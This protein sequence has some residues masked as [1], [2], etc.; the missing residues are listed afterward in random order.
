MIKKID[1]LVLV[2]FLGPF[3]VSFGIALFVLIMQ[4]LWLYIDDIAGKGVN[5][6]IM[7]ELIAYLSI[8]IFPMALPVAVMLATVMVMGN[9]AERYE[10]SSMKSAGISLL[11][12][13]APLMFA[14]ALI[15]LFS[16]VC[17]DFLMPAANLKFKTRMFDIKR[18]K[19]A[20]S[21]EKGIFNEDFQ[22]FVIRVG[23]KSRDGETIRDVM[24]IDQSAGSRLKFNEILADSGQM[25][26][27]KDK[28]YFVMNLFDGVQYQEPAP[29]PSTGAQS[30]YPFVRI[31][32]E[33][34]TKV[35]DMQEF[36]LTRSDEDHFRSNRQMMSMSQL[37]HARDSMEFAMKDIRQG[38]AR[39]V[40]LSLE[41][42]PVP[43]ASEPASAPV[44]HGQPVEIRPLELQDF[45]GGTAWKQDSLLEPL[46]Q[47][48]TLLHTFPEADRDLIRQ[49]ASKRVQ[50]QA[51]A[52]ETRMRQIESRHLQQVK[53][54][55]DLYLKYSFAIICLLF[56]FIGGPMGAIIRKGGFGYPIL[57]AIVFF[58]V[59]VML[60]ITFRKLAEGLWFSPFWAAM[61]PWLLMLPVAVVLTWKAINDSRMIN[62][63]WLDR[64]R[65]RRNQKAA[66]SL[67]A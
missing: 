21:I 7:V 42:T 47:Y 22:Q 62:F 9:L 51:S 36:E 53:V 32:F 27:T 15:G 18:Q 56:L 10:L 61:M 13:M 41:R 17:S 30:S 19:P 28:R 66:V 34:M 55:Y 40:L 37:R 5:L 57:V 33:Q 6:F 46:H 44:V 58:V 39:D 26:T 14:C 4:F 45:R 52:V 3:L 2:S 63:D 38:I 12:V 64:L 50:L 20:L 1:R 59:F 31:G 54:A 8:S 23:D 48:T 67:P 11:R 25:Y 29:A 60:T 65:L 35:W 16:Y 24:I 49:E 43:P